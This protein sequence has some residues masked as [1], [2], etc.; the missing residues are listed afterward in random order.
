MTGRGIANQCTCLVSPGV[1]SSSSHISCSY[2]RRYIAQGSEV[3]AVSVLVL[4]DMSLAMDNLRHFLSL[5]YTVNALLIIGYVP[6]RFYW[7]QHGLSKYSRLK[8]LDDVHNWESQCGGMIL[9]ILAV[10]SL[11]SQLTLDSLLA[12]VFLYIKAG[13]VTVAFMVDPRV[14]IYVSI[15]F[16]LT[17]LMAPQPYRDFAGHHKTEL[18]SMQ[19]FQ[20][21]VVN[22]PPGTCWLVLYFMPNKIGKQV[23]AVFASLSL[24]YA[25]D[26]LHFGRVN[27]Q[28]SPALAASSGF[29]AQSSYY[30]ASIVMYK[31]TVA[32]RRHPEQSSVEPAIMSANSIAKAFEL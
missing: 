20:E 22:G 9:F 12:D 16:L 17:Y 6:V 23:N 32:V 3:V 21:Q 19:S 30:G 26:Q 4:D 5:Y 31:G 18:L 1:S 7:Y 13:I 29:Q 28:S 10:K 8:N 27:L 25:D 24:T 15:V 14:S 11:R 2:V